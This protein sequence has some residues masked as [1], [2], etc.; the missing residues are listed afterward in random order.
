LNAADIVA[1]ICLDV[2]V[3]T[4]SERM[5]GEKAF[6]FTRGLRLNFPMKL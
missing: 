1:T 3:P 2:F 6:H 4:F 5:K